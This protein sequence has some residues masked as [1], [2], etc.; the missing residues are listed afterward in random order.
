MITTD[1]VSV[2]GGGGVT[3][4]DALVEDGLAREALA[5]RGLA[6]LLESEAAAAA[7]AAVGAMP[8]LR[9]L[10]LMDVLIGEAVELAVILDRACVLEE[11]GLSV[12]VGRL[13]AASVSPRNVAIYASPGPVRTGD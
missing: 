2:A 10:E 1:L 3:V 12:R 4:E 11:A 6:P 9:R 13:F 5:A 8:A 7:A